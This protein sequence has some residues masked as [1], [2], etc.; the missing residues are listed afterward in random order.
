MATI[1][2]IIAYFLAKYPHTHELSKARLTKMVYLADWVAAI[3][4][5]RQL[6]DIEWYFNHYGPYVHD[7]VE[8]ARADPRF[9]IVETRTLYGNPKETVELARKPVTWSSL[10]PQD[11][12]VL[13]HVI[14]QTERLTWDGFIRAVYSTY[15]IATQARG[16]FLNLNKLAREY[17]AQQRSG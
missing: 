11:I 14:A 4:F 5:G 8:H 13:E 2:D 15:P 1:G 6:T 7:V 16:S 3:S 12:Q 9:K 10:T 17:R